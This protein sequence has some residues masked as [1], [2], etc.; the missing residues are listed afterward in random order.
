MLELVYPPS[1]AT[2]LKEQEHNETES[3]QISSDAQYV[4]N[5]MLSISSENSSSL[6]NSEKYKVISGNI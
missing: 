4:L 5:Q 6:A 1:V 2:Q 3:L